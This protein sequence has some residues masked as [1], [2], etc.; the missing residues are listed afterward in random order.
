MNVSYH[1]IQLGQNFWES[2][3]T[4]KLPLGTKGQTQDGRVY[5]YALAGASDLVAGNV[6]QSPAIVANHL[7]MTPA[8]T[9]LNAFTVTAT[10]GATAGAANL[11]AE[12]YLDV[13]TTPGNGYVYTIKDHLAIGSG[14]SFSVN[15]FKDD[16]IQVAL[17]T[18]S[19]VGLVQNV[20][21]GVIQAPVTTATGVIVGVAPYIIKATQ[22]G[23]IQ[24]YGPASTLINGTP[25]LG[26]A[27]VGISATTAGSVD[28]ITT[29]NLVTAPIIG[30]MMQVGVS[31]KNNWVFLRIAE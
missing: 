8:A 25:A 5:R 26:A 14:A 30:H 16:P 6:I 13:D 29:T 3:A 20:Y 23:W 17:T 15:L 22:Y 1:P 18:S 24:T 2:S 11:Y 9:A 10:A 27:V 19:R 28:V 4:Q 7:A 12:G 21:S 31:T